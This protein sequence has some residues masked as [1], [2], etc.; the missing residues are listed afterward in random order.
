[1]NRT[2]QIDQGSLGLPNRKYFLKGMNDT[3]VRAYYDTMVDMALA[4]GAKNKSR[5]EQEMLDVIKFE[6]QLANVS[7]AAER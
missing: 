5:V 2:S 4:L 7:Q 3:T 1:M 6:T